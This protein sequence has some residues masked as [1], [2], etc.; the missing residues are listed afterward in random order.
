MWLSSSLI[1]KV[2]V[3]HWCLWLLASSSTSSL[4]CE[5]SEVAWFG[6]D[7]WDILTCWYVAGCR[8]TE[9]ARGNGV[10]DCRWLCSQFAKSKTVPEDCSEVGC[11]DLSLGFPYCRFMFHVCCV[12]VLHLWNSYW[13]K[14]EKGHNLGPSSFQS[15]N[16]DPSCFQF[17]L[18]LHTIHT[19]TPGWE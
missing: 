7:I 2:V 10:Q 6:L 11:F 12:L 15:F 5:D 3:M 9:F 17:Q 14:G 13:E 19:S 8:G 16:D 4:G 18:C 1:N